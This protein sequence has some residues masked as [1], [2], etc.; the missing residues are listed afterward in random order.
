LKTLIIACN[1]CCQEELV[2]MGRPFKINGN[3]TVREM[4]NINVEGEKTPGNVAKYL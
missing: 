3:N 4:M 1:A 2:E